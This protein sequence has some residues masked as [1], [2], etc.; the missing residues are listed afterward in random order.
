[1]TLDQEVLGSSPSRATR[2]KTPH[3]LRMG[4]LFF[5]TLFC[6]PGEASIVHPLQ[7]NPV[8]HI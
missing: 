1:M 4:R 6:P 5:L 8:S 7:S 2:G 3:T